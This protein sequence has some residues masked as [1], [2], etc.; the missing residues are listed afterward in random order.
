MNEPVG[1]QSGWEEAAAF[2]CGKTAG[3]S[4]VIWGAD[5]LV[6]RAEWFLEYDHDWTLSPEDV[7]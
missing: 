4:F 2:F 6:S 7:A 3:W 1:M 5:R